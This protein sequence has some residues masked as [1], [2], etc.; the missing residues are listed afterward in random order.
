[1]SVS[2]TRNPFF[3]ASLPGCVTIC[4]VSCGAVRTTG[5]WLSMSLQGLRPAALPRDNPG[6][7]DRVPSAPAAWRS[8]RLRLIGARIGHIVP[9]WPAMV[10]VVAPRRVAFWRGHGSSDRDRGRFRRRWRASDAGARPAMR[11]RTGR[12]GSAGRVRGR[13]VRLRGRVERFAQRLDQD[14][15]IRWASSH[16]RA[17]LGLWRAT[18]RSRRGSSAA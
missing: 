2:Y 15:A 12:A 9:P 8:Q 16:D 4:A 17:S 6:L 14:R 1:M 3:I 18:R 10:S 13:C 7:S 5:S 11:A